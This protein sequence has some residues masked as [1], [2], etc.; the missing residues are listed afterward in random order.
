MADEIRVSPT[1]IQ[2]N[3]NDIAMELTQ[4]YYSMQPANKYT[5]EDIQDAYKKFYATAKKSYLMKNAEM[6]E[7]LGE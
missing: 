6:D 1:P 2:R 3:L 7:V 4:L 5:I